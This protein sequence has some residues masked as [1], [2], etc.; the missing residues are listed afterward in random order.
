MAV[1][2]SFIGGAGWQFFDDNGVPLAGGKIYTYAAGTTTP[3]TTYTSRD[4]STPNTNPII[5]DAAGRTP[6]QIWATE[7]LLYKY[8]VQTANDVLVRSWDNIG[9][10]VVSSDLTQNLANTTNNSLGDA[11]IGF[12]QSNSSGF[13]PGAVARTVN[14]KLQEIVSVRDFG[15]IGDGITDD[16]A[17][18]QA[19]I[20]AATSADTKVLVPPGT[21]LL[22]DTLT[23]NTTLVFDGGRFSTGYTIKINGTA[24]MLAHN[25][26]GITFNQSSGYIG[27]LPNTYATQVLCGLD[28][29][30]S[31]R[32][33]NLLFDFNNLTDA[34]VISFWNCDGFEVSNNQL[35][36]LYASNGGSIIG[37]PNSS[38]GIV[39]AMPRSSKNGKIYNNTLKFLNVPTGA[40]MCGVTQSENIS[41]FNNTFIGAGD[42]IINIDS[43]DRISFCNNYCSTRIGTILVNVSTNFTIIGNTIVKEN[44]QWKSPGVFSGPFTGGGIALHIVDG[45]QAFGARNGIVANNLIINNDALYDMTQPMTIAGVENVTVINNTFINNRPNA[46]F[47]F[48]VNNSGS[49]IPGTT[50][51][52]KNLIVKNN[53]VIRG[54]YNVNNAGSS[55][56]D[57][58][59]FTDNVANGGGYA[60][61]AMNLVDFNVTRNDYADNNLGI[62]ATSRS[63]NLSTSGSAYNPRTLLNVFSKNSV[64]TSTY[65][66]AV[67]S[68]TFFY[69]PYDTVLDQVTVQF[70]AATS[71]TG[72]LYLYTHNGTSNTLIGS[73]TM[74]SGTK[75]LNAMETNEGVRLSSVIVPA[76]NSVRFEIVSS[77]LGSVDMSVNLYGSKLVFQ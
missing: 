26:G 24:S 47:V 41:F 15:A 23:V 51:Y 46:N 14:T 8:V 21:Y 55:T 19:A 66:N 65:L 22:T 20:N 68:G 57:G 10:S 69:V 71:A 45:S 75:A 59:I 5:L 28:S 61:V 35:L 27:T 64:T 33:D 6:S 32:I 39:G 76:G 62:G 48:G 16:T 49:V 4:A 18:I 56:S 34:Y 31:G 2:L 36:N 9:G 25:G 1:N 38:T 52:N 13:L 77:G 54:R 7:G 17:A 63:Q 43:S 50:I 74:S 73:W 67:G 3:Q 60:V 53:T 58:V 30:W 29:T 42:D 40:Q 44:A 11:L 72:V 70:S 12:K 37:S